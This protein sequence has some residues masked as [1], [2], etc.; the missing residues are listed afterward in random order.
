MINGGMNI[1]QYYY[2]Q[3]PDLR[4]SRQGLVLLARAD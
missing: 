4:L 2:Q 3:H 1:L